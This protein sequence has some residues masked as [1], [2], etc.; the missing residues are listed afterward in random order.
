MEE[1]VIGFQFNAQGFLPT[2][3]GLFYERVR[4]H[5]P[6]V[7]TLPAV[8]TVP[9]GLPFAFLGGS[10]WPRVLFVA[11]DDCSLIQLQTDRLYFN[12]RRKP[13]KPEYPHY[14]QVRE[15]F[16]EVYTNFTEFAKS[17]F[18]VCA[19]RVSE[20]I[21]VNQITQQNS[22]FGQDLDI[23]GVFRAWNSDVG[24]E[25]PHAVKELAFNAQYPLV[26]AEGTALEG[27]L[28]VNMTSGRDPQGSPVARLEIGASGNINDAST[29]AVLA[30]HDLGHAAIVNAFAA[31]TSDEA[32][33][34][35]GRYQ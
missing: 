32:H 12:W 26:K 2:H 9:G 35:W 30:F 33:Q 34:K 27:V 20:I 8:S 3:F 21:Y 31:I 4:S 6:S 16:G 18:G 23:G 5:Y 14:E 28:T 22:G 1:V 10:Q 25:W 13:H 15:K 11:A 7:Q 29:D 24:P 19:P 17:E